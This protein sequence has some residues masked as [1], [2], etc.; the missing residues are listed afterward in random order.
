MTVRAN[1]P[2]PPCPLPSSMSCP[3]TLSHDKGQPWGVSSKGNRKEFVRE[4]FT[5]A[6][7][8]RRG[9]RWPFAGRPSRRQ[10]DDYRVRAGR[11]S[12]RVFVAEPFEAQADRVRYPHGAVRPIFVPVA[13]CR[14]ALRSSPAR[15][16][17]VRRCDGRAAAF[18]HVDRQVDEFRCLDAKVC[19]HFVGL[20]RNDS[21]P[22][23]DSHAVH[24]VD[25]ADR[26]ARLQTT[27]RGQERTHST[28]GA[29]RVG[30]NPV[31]QNPRAVHR[32]RSGARSRRSASGARGPRVRGGL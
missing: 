14:Q 5:N 19:R 11:P 10:S 16:S 23:V 9:I 18:H 31:S 1:V 8:R 22:A 13:P 21:S 28:R 29:R 27:R 12:S 25:L 32:T 24:V 30:F 7:F 20:C 3:V 2:R 15:G 17:H 6:P 26:A 4:G